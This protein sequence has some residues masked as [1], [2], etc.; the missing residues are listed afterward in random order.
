[1]NPAN[2]LRIERRLTNALRSKWNKLALNFAIRVNRLAEKGDF[3]RARM[4]A[5]TFTM[6]PVL[7]GNKKVISDVTRSA[8][9][10]GAANTGTRPSAALI[11]NN[12]PDEEHDLLIEQLATQITISATRQAREALHRDIDK[13]ELEYAKVEKATRS[14]IIIPFQSFADNGDKSLQL[15]S[16]LHSSRVSS[17][18]FLAEA[19]LEGYTQYQVN[20]QLDTLI[21]PVCEVMH[22]KTFEVAQAQSLLS[23]VI[24]ETDPNL[25]AAKQPWPSQKPDDV[26]ALSN[27]SNEEIYSKGYHLPPYHPN[28]RGLIVPV[29]TIPSIPSLPSSQAAGVP[30]PP[31]IT[32]P[33]PGITFNQVEMV[34]TTGKHLESIADK[35]STG[36]TKRFIKTAPQPK[37]TDKNGKGAWYNS[38]ENELH[39]DDSNKLGGYVFMHEYGHHADYVL[40]RAKDYR[41]NGRWVSTNDNEFKAAYA[42]DRKNLRLH[43]K[44]ERKEA[45]EKLKERMQIVTYK[46]AEFRGE[47]VRLVDTVERMPQTELIEDILDAM[48]QGQ[49]RRKIGL[50]GHG[51]SYYKSN[52]AR[53]IETFANLFALDGAEAGT[54]AL[55]AELFPNLVKRW[56][57]LMEEYNG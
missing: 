19:R 42:E 39:I 26:K 34:H 16:S 9:L 57:E 41:L 48:T 11:K 51:Q 2:F 23:S 18:G 24:R 37:I 54:K 15:L 6:A 3:T 17:Q 32:P 46:E 27:F 4:L 52:A 36:R 56:K 7:S 53:Y 35:L 1:M 29:G 33:Q 8:M 28:C 5:D 21:C 31:K 10:F 12:Y 45:V 47:T 25:I 49:I 14:R 13:L 44:A 50:F 38:Y 40:G 22:G 55:V 30:Q 20:E 43:R